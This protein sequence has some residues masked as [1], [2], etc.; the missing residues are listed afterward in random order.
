MKSYDKKEQENS[1]GFKQLNFSKKEGTK[2]LTVLKIETIVILHLIFQ[3][4]LPNLEEGKRV[5][6]NQSL[7]IKTSC[8]L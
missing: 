4:T 2:G 8:F 3:T 1:P 7:V 6:M 5:W